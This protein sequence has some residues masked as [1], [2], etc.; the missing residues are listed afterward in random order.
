MKRTSWCSYFCKNKTEFDQTLPVSIS[1]PA[2][3]GRGPQNSS[4]NN[5][6]AGERSETQIAGPRKWLGL[7]NRVLQKRQ[8]RENS[9]QNMCPWVLSQGLSWKHKE[10]DWRP[11]GN[12][13]QSPNLCVQ[14][15]TQKERREGKN[16]RSRGKNNISKDLEK[17]FNVLASIHNKLEIKGDSWK[18]S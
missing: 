15:E 13:R 3:Q 10:E 18:C 8:L 2:V 4:N 1:Q 11:T 16:D 14:F 17:V 5:T 12:R 7:A 9:I 6:F